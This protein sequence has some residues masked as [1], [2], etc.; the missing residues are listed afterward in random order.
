MA[1]PRTS[2]LTGT[3]ITLI[4]ITGIVMAGAIALA[5][6]FTLSSSSSTGVKS[7]VGMG[8]RTTTSTSAASVFPSTTNVPTTS[9]L[10]TTT[11]QAQTVKVSVCGGAPEYEPKV[12]GWCTSLCSPY[13]EGIRWTVWDSSHAIGNGTLV[14][15]EGTP[16][17]AEGR[18]TRTPYEV[19]LSNPA[20]RGICGPRGKEQSLVFTYVNIWAAT[21]PTMDPTCPQ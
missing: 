21:I 11:A 6:I 20:I 5:R 8:Q 12:L 18:L 16:S 13:V 15:N 7:A 4:A 2:K 10:P 17:C 3:H 14:T 19:Q 1:D 9:A